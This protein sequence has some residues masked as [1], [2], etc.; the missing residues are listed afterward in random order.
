MAAKDA[1]IEAGSLTIHKLRGGPFDNNVYALICRETGE[2]ALVDS[3]FGPERVLPVLKG[4]KLRFILQTH[5]H[6]DHVRA[7]EALRARTGAPV[8]LHPEEE[9]RFGVRGD[10]Q[11]NHGQR[12]AF[13]E[14]SLEVRHTPGHSPG[15]VLLVYPSH[16]IC[17]DTVFPGGP[18]KTGSPRD[19]QTLLAS[20]EREVYTLPDETVLYPG[21]GENTT[22]GESKK[23][24]A[25]F[26]QR[27][28]PRPGQCG[29][30]LWLGS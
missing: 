27:G 18:G 20:I 13:G 6:G 16:C 14:Q 22:V 10:F 4:T 12:V 5:C 23:E 15:G 25:V 29:D 28:G 3:S 7:L 2:S 1:V 19:L 26:R 9:R 24:Y 30:V 21:H 11:L 8:G 17:G